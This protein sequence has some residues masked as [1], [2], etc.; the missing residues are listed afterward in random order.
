MT[1]QG[2]NRRD[3]LKRTSQWVL[4]VLCLPLARF[5]DPLKKSS[6]PVPASREARHYKSADHLAG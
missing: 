5:Q 6:R 4:G 3:F 1:K 2:I